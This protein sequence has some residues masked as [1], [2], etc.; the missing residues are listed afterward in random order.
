MQGLIY[1]EPVWRLE[2]SQRRLNYPLVNRSVDGDELAIIDWAGGEKLSAFKNNSAGTRALAFLRTSQH[3]ADRQGDGRNVHR[4][5]AHPARIG[6]CHCGK[7]GLGVR[8]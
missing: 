7:G 4:G 2:C 6:S 5:G 8:E 3:G 1:I